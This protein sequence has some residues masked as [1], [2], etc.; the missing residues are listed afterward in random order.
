MASNRVKAPVAPGS[1][2][3]CM[4]E[5]SHG[6]SA[7]NHVFRGSHFRET[8]SL[9]CYEAPRGGTQAML[10]CGQKSILDAKTYTN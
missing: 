6:S 4:A 7:T 5:T 1:G 9:D 8:T 10:D 2:W 3:R